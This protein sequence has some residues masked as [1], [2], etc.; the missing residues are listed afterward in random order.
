MKAC[1]ERLRVEDKEEEEIGGDVD[2]VCE[3]DTKLVTCSCGVWLMGV[4]SV[5]CDDWLE[6]RLSCVGVC[7]TLV[8]PSYSSSL[9]LLSPQLSETMKASSLSLSGTREEQTGTSSREGDGGRGGKGG[10]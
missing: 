6:G 2:S 8:W 7:N 1:K 9:A 3:E 4:V 5:D 10:V